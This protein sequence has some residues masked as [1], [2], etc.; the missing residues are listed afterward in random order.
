LTGRRRVGYD[1]VKRVLDVAS[2]TA[3]FIITSP[4]Q[5]G[6]AV[7]VAVKLGRPVLFRQARP[8]KDG[9]IF[10]LVKFRTMANADSRTSDVAHDAARLSRFGQL[11]RSTSLDELPTLVNVIKGDMSIVGPRPL[12]VQYLDRYTAVQARRHEVRPGVTGLAQVKGRNL[13]GWDRKFELDVEYVDKRSIWLDA[14][15]LYWTIAAVLKRD[16]IAAADHAT[17]HEFKGSGDKPGHT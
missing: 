2:A 7:A 13:L 5:L 11:L 14:K 9:K 16:G 10:T 8:G 6:V 1:N 4:I 17:T 15:I 3:A 12:L